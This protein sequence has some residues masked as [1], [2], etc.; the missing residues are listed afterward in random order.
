MIQCV[1]K[2]NVREYVES[3]GLGYILNELY[4]V[5]DSVDKINFD[6]LPE[7]FVLKTTNGSETNYFCRDKRKIKI[8]EVKQKMISF[9]AMPNDFAGREWAYK[10]SSKLIVA[11]KFMVDDSNPD[12]S[13][14]DYKFLCFGGE[15]EYVVYDCDRFSGHKRNIYDMKWTNLKIDSDCP[16]IER[17]IPK[18][19][20]F[21]EMI[22]IARILSSD[23]PAVRV[24]LYNIKGQIIFGELTFYPWSGYVQFTPDEFDYEVGNKFILPI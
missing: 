15:P 8:D 22:K 1:D 24:D 17:D 14:S 9:L 2:Y 4:Q 18:P 19:P 12:G 20:R 21:E 13:I 10:D 11:E 16:Q 23:F 5:V 3:K 7:K 6:L